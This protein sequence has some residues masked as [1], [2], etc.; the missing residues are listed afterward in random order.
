MCFFLLAGVDLINPGLSVHSNSPLRMLT[1]NTHVE[2]NA[3]VDA[4]PTSASVTGSN[5]LKITVF[6]SANSDGSGERY[7]STL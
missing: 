7:V 6:A 3:Y 1:P 2:F 5:L 4:A